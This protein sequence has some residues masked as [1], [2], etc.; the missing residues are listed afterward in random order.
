MTPE[1]QGGLFQSFSQAD[2]STTRRYGGTGLGLAISKKLVEL[3]GGRIWIDSEYAKGSTFH[4]H[5]RFELQ[6]EPM[7]RRRITSSELA[8]KRLLVIDDNSS[9]R[10]I[11]GHRLRA[12]RGQC[13]G[14][15]A[16]IG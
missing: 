14:R 2:A 4:F 8:G 7:P 10:E 9:A 15:S 12:G 3:M 16:G 11:H 6:A 5:A 1:Q 13:L